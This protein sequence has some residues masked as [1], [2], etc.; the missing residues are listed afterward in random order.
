MNHPID[1]ELPFV[2]S[3]RDQD[4]KAGDERAQYVSI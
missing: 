1:L 4:E 2:D 3:E